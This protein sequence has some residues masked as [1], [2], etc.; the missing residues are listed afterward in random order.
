LRTLDELVNR[1]DPGID[2]IRSWLGEASHPVELL[3]CDRTAGERAL[4]ALQVTTRS[5]MGALAYESGGLLVD[6]GWLRVLGAGCP[7]LPRSLPD[8]N[9]IAGDA[10]PPR[11]PGT[12]LIA[13]DVVGGF[14]AVN[15]GGLPGTQGN[16][17]YLAPDTLEWEDVDLG[18][19]GW[20]KWACTGNL[21][22][23]YENARWPGWEHDVAQIGGNQGISIQPFLFTDGPPVADRS[24]R[25]IPI[26]ELWGLHAIE[27][28]R[29]LRDR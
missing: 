3:P 8:W 28:P 10:K 21:A 9:R 16:V 27:L 14:F 2:M 13:D 17:F 12:V 1:E 24:R 26:D 22:Q 23:F 19:S 4:L 6:H 11:L 25:A 7:R 15:A 5:P 29:Q 18:Y 20:M